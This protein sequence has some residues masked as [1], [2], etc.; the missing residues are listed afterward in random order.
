MLYTWREIV[1]L[2]GVSDD[3]VRHLFVTFT[4]KLT[5]QDQELKQKILEIL[6]KKTYGRFP[7]Q[8]SQTIDIEGVRLYLS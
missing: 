3:R 1:L 2:T 4:S 8:H 6:Y 5:Q 7:T